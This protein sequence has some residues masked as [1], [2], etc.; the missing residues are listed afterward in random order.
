MTA[1]SLP[2]RFPSSPTRFPRAALP[3]FI[4]WSLVSGAFLAWP[5]MSV[6]APDTETDSTTVPDSDEA[7]L[8]NSIEVEATVKEGDEAVYVDE[9]RATSQVVET[10]GAEQIARTGDSDTAQTLKRVTGLSVVDGKHVFVRGLGDRYSSVLLNGAQLPSPDP[11]RRTVPLDLFPTE[12]LDG[13]VVQKSY[14]PN[15]P[16]EFGGGAV[17]LRTRGVPLERRGKIGA[18]LGFAD[19][20]TFR[21]GLGYAGGSQDWT[22]FEDA[23]E[24]PDDLRNAIEGG[25]ILRPQSPTNPEGFTAAQL[26]QFG[27]SLAGDYDV[28]TRALQ[29]NTSAG[30]SFGNAFSFGERTFGVMAAIRYANQWDNTDEMRRSFVSTGDGLAETSAL[31]FERTR[32]TVDVSSFV[33]AGLDWS[34]DHRYK[35][36]NMLLRSTEDD[37]N[38]A[39]GF[40]DDPEDISR[41]TELEWIENKLLANQL[42]GEHRFAS[43]RDLSLNWQYTHASAGRDAPKTRRYRFDRNTATGEF[44]FSRRS[45]SNSTVYAGLDDQSQDFGLEA[46]LPVSLGESSWMDLYA[47][48][49]LVRRE[50]DSAIRRFTF[51]G[52]GPLATDP[53]VLVRPGFDDVVNPDTI[54]SNGFQLRETTR[55]TDNYTADQDLDAVFVG[56][57]I[58]WNSKYRLALGVRQERNDQQV[59]TFSISDPGAAPT[60]SRIDTDDLLPSVSFTWFQGDASQWRASYGETVSRPEFRELSRAPFTDPLLDLETIG[61]PDLRP[62]SVQHLD[63]R[64]EHYFSETE[65]FSAAIF[66]KEFDDPIEKIQVPGTGNLVS[67]ANAESASNHGIELDYAR[68][69][70]A[71]SD[72]LEDW[73]LGANYAWIDS[74]VELGD[75]ND[76]QTN[77]ER[78]LQGQSPH[79]GNIQLGFRREG[80][81]ATLLYNV[82]GPRISQVGI[83]GAPDIEER[84]FHQ[85]DFNFR[86]DLAEDLVLKVKLRN[87]LDPKVE[88]TQGGFTTREYRRGREVSVGLDW[89]F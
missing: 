71:F 66:A 28:R 55:G 77:S 13:L 39:E 68:G 49:N 6:A 32:R 1:H 88:F 70:G 73:Y 80:T 81:E 8:L 87:L 14:A 23:R 53:D 4:A 21:D 64:F 25:V 37:T 35:Y 33:V 89:T 10:L 47:G 16:G 26:E 31:A 78:P 46:K 27:E 41:F 74:S 48:A 11:T 57:D 58:N 61:N 22:G 50:R 44:G 79:V 34:A 76:I 82:F 5:T 12:I 84:P 86:H 62:A 59:S 60:I 83:F 63:I 45:D 42:S 38:V 17:L 54:G 7:S 20:T 18:S 56:A 69:L 40:V 2:R 52:V 19:G 30:A 9:R 65:T 85:V 24:L 15:L 67:F 72:R 51:T 75:A 43:L 3:A 29:P 36:T